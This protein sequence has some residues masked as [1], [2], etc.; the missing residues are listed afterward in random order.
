VPDLD[1]PGR[2]F[3][4]GRAEVLRQGDDLTIIALGTAV[5]LAVAAAGVLAAE[6]IAARVLNH[7][8]L[9]P[10]D[11]DALRAAAATGAIVTAEEAHVAGGLGGAV[12]EWC[13]SHAPTPLER[14]GFPGFLPTGSV[15]DLFADNGLTPAGIAAAARR[16]LARKAR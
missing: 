5:H 10:L 3:R 11:E 9:L 8:T 4:V 6:G 13:G 1:V 16:A 7:A 2:Q 12:A 14:V 15:A